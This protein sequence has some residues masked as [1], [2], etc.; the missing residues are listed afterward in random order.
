MKTQQIIKQY[1]PM[2]QGVIALFAPFVEC[3]IHDI[4][5]GKIV[6]IYNNI[7]KRKIGDLSPLAELN[8]PVER[9]PDVFEP[10]YETNWNGHKIKCT[11]I[12]IRDENRKP[13]F[14]ICFNFDTAVFQDIQLNLKTFLQVKETADNPVELFGEGWQGKIDTFI[15]G[16]LT[17]NKLILSSISRENK[18][19]LIEELS[20]HG[21]FFYKKA[22]DYVASK[23]QLSR[24]TIYNYLKVLRAND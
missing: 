22:P 4:Q 14:L 17:R 11:S 3:A 13:L 21:V 20:R 24:A 1:E 10:Y 8:T 2:I 23:L 7:S 18:Q 19:E 6:A 15:E 16:Y 5:T 9:F 12:T